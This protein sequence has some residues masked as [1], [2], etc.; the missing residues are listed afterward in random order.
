MGKVEVKEKPAWLIYVKALGLFLISYCAVEA[1]HT[2]MVEGFGSASFAYYGVL[3]M[4][5]LL[6]FLASCV[7]E[8]MWEKPPIKADS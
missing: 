7:F 8:K 6:L 4:L 5:G 1:G 3:V 2:W